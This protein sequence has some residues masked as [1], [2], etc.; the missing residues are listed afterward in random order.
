MA[1]LVRSSSVGPMPPVQMTRSASATASR[2]DAGQPLQVIADLDDVQQL[3]SLRG[4]L[5]GEEGGIG[6]GQVTTHQLAADG[7]NVRSHRNRPP[8]RDRPAPAGL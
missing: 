4:Q 2:E 7:E 6:V 5:L 3:N 1:S 8:T